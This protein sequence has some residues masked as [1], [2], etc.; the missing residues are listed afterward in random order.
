MPSLETIASSKRPDESTTLVRDDV[1]DQSSTNYNTTTSENGN[2]NGY[3]DVHGR[4]PI[5]CLDFDRIINSYSIAATKAR[6][7]QQ[8]RKKQKE[9]HADDFDHGDSSSS[10]LSASLEDSSPSY[11]YKEEKQ[12]MSASGRTVARWVLTCVVAICTGITAVVILFLQECFVDFRVNRLNRQ[13]QWAYGHA[14]EE[15]IILWY[16]Q[17]RFFDITARGLGITGVYIGYT[18]YN[19]LLVLTSASLVLLLAPQ[20]AGSGIPEVKAYLN[21]VR[22][23]TFAD[24]KLFFTTALG[25]VF[26]V[27]SGLVIGPEGPVVHLGAIIGET[28]TKTGDIEG[29]LRLFRKSHPEASKLLGCADYEQLDT[30]DKSVSILSSSSSSDSNRKSSY[31]TGINN[32]FISSIVFYFSHFRNDIERRRLISIGVACGFASAFGAPVGGLL[33]SMEEASSFF[34]LDLLWKTLTATA[35]ASTC[36]AIYHG[37]FTRYSMLSLEIGDTSEPLLASFKEVPLY[38]VMGGCGGLLGAAFNTAYAYINKSRKTF[39]DGIAPN[40]QDEV[41]F[42]KLLECAAISIVTSILML[43]LPLQASWACQDINIASGDEQNDG[44]FFDRYNCKSGQINEIG[45]LLFG[46]REESIKDVLTNPENFQPETLLSVGLLFLGLM[47]VTFGISIP[48][49]MFMP[50]VL[51]GASL[52]GYAGLIFQ[53]NFISSVHPSDFALIGAAAFLAGMQRNTVSLC[54]I[55]MESTGQTKTL[56]PVMMTVCVARSVGDFFSEGT[57]E[58]GIELKHF[59]CMEHDTEYEYDMYKSSTIMTSP[60]QT[61]SNVE[62]VT[63]IET[64]LLQCT[65]N[66]FP[67]IDET[68]NRHKGMV[69]R[70]QLIAAI[71]CRIFTTNNST[72]PTV[73][74]EDAMDDNNNNNTDDDFPD[75]TESVSP[76]LRDNVL[77]YGEYIMFGM[78][79]TLPNGMIRRRHHQQQHGDAIDTTSL[80]SSVVK[81]VDDKLVVFVASYDKNK[82]VNVGSIMNRKAYSVPDDCPLSRAYDLFT[83]MG[84]RHLPVLNDT[85]SVVGIISRYNF[86]KEWVKKKTSSL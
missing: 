42:F 83:S 35:L 82:Y 36:I 20:A 43:T 51:S 39:Y 9:R 71:E 59:P 46:S 74:A 85:N 34:S 11:P 54:V 66:A 25:T 70:D 76:W 86:S 28:I 60:V 84:L 73:A 12:V 72:T 13:L 58:I 32:Y 57:Y 45:S 81:V 62:S 3:D 14:I 5:E 68:T 22:V 56:M 37:D 47:I 10:L 17:A 80:S 4:Y 64:L 29:R 15:E 53:Q 19:L 77:V 6:H 30:T 26:A 31:S 63:K 52:G 49:G 61:V 24:T 27:S 40:K 48:S 75:A 23:P 18:L 79:E 55:L 2:I 44:G 16:H 78:D 50:T 41:I 1:V 8:Q 38:F 67:V 7:R 21:G 33:Y 69:R 65:H